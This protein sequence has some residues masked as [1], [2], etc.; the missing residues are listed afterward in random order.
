MKNLKTFRNFRIVI[1]TLALSLRVVTKSSVLMDLSFWFRHQDLSISYYSL[2]E[3]LTLSGSRSW[4]PVKSNLT[5]DEWFIMMPVNLSFINS[6]TSGT[7]H[8]LGGHGPDFF[9]KKS[10]KL[11]PGSEIIHAS[12]VVHR[13]YSNMMSFVIWLSAKRA[14][15]EISALWHF[16]KR[17]RTG[18]SAKRARTEISALGK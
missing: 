14:R 7:I 9:R 6:I 12:Q 5:N 13:S 3:N 16:P 4:K 18:I 1:M 10:E 17:A 15:T 8:D 2:M 11:G